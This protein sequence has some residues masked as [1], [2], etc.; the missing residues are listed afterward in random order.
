MNEVMESWVGEDIDEVI[1][2]WGYPTKERTVSGR[3][4]YY[5]VDD[6][7]YISTTLTT[8]LRYGQKLSCTKIFEVDKNNKIIR[9]QWKGNRCPKNGIRGNKLINP[10]SVKVKQKGD[11]I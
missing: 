8:G 5:W 10:K 9:G 2:S 11:E 7:K 3:K 6:S 1:D 4:L